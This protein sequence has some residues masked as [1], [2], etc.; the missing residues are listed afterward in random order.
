MKR[1]AAMLGWWMT[2]CVQQPPPR[3]APVTC[4]FVVV[5]PDSTYVTSVR[6]GVIPRVEP[7]PRPLDSIRLGPVQTV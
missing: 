2:A 3:V 7:P 6:C 5:W 4:L 1:F